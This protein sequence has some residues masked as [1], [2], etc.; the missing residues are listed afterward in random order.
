MTLKM[1][2]RNSDGTILNLKKENTLTSHVCV[3]YCGNLHI[4]TLFGSKTKIL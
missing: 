1:N 3:R 2:G 4:N